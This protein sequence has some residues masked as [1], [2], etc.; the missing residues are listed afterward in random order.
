MPAYCA[1]KGGIIALT[2]GAALE[3]AARGFVLTPYALALSAR[4]W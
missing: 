2:R 1:S 3:Y 4:R